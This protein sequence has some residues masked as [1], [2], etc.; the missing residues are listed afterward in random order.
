MKAINLI[1]I[2]IL[3]LCGLLCSCSKK[4]KSEQQQQQINEENRQLVTENIPED[5]DP[6]LK[7]AI[8][9]TLESQSGERRS[10]ED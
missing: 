2:T 8:E 10:R 1:L 5:A 9:K 7:K 4:N 6:K 3:I